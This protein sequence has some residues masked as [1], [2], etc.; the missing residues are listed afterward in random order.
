MNAGEGPSMS[1]HTELDPA[2][3]SL[4]RPT[5]FQRNL[6]VIPLSVIIGGKIML[7]RHHTLNQYRSSVSCGLNTVLSAEDRARDEKSR[8]ATLVELTPKGGEAVGPRRKREVG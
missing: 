4:R 8:A 2:P 6:L 5:R 1:P 3:V 7:T